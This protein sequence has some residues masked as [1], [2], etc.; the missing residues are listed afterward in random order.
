MVPDD[1]SPKETAK[2]YINL[3]EGTEYKPRPQ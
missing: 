1:S 3:S 2:T